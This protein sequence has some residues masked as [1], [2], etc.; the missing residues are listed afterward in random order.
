MQCLRPAVLLALVT[1][2][3]LFGGP[4]KPKPVAHTCYRT[5]GP[6]LS[7]DAGRDARWLMLTDSGGQGV[8]ARWYDG[9]MSGARK[10]RRIQ[11]QS[12]GPGAI[13]VR[14]G[15]GAGTM[16]AAEV[17][18]ILSGTAQSGARGWRVNALREAC[19]RDL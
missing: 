12:T 5:T 11:W 2:C 4:S 16:E 17:R 14:W 6:L 3:G 7:P 10:P 1:G 13:R 18:G 8:G 19:P 9:R 15:D